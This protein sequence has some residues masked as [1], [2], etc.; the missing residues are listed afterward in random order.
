MFQNK[1]K[2]DMIVELNS[3]QGD[4]SSRVML[5]LL[6]ILI[7]ETRI[8]NDHCSPDDL[9]YNQGVIGAYT[10]MKEYILRGIPGKAQA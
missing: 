4:R 10:N 8:L 9:P 3:L 1:E 7:T 5:K 6:D 2:V